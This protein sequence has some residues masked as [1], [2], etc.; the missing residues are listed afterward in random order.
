L[1]SGRIPRVADRGNL[2]SALKLLRTRLNL[3]RVDLG[4]KLGL[5]KQ[6]LWSQA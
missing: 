4:R 3:N 5:A 2:P 6:R 1:G